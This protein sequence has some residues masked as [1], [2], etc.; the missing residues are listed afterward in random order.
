MADFKKTL[1]MVAVVVLIISLIFLGVMMSS[2]SKDAKWPPKV[3]ECPDFWQEVSGKKPNGDDF[4]K[5]NNINNLGKSSCKK[6]MDFSSTTWAGSEGECRKSNWAKGCDI[7]WD[8]VT[9]NSTICD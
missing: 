6:D 4:V 9:N 5:C 8:G 2:K 1:L 3:A 7:T